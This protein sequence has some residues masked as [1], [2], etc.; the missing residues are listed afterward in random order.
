MV[1]IDGKGSETMQTNR[2]NDLRARVFISCGQAKGSAEESTA[3]ALAARLQVEGF[4]PYIAVQ[5]QTLRGL[6]ENIFA[7]LAQSEY[8]V[9]IDFKREPLEGTDPPVCRGSLFTHQE[10]AIASY[11][12]MPLLAFQESG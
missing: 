4:D 3:S 1:G 9:F 11:L 5:E 2:A 8:F 12:D 6:R 10:L 7:Q